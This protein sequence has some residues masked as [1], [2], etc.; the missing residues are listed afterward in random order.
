MKTKAKKAK[1]N[2]VLSTILWTLLSIVVL[3]LALLWPN[4]RT[5]GQRLEPADLG[6]WEGVYSSQWMSKLPEDTRLS[7]ISMAGSHD[8]GTEY[9]LLPLI[10]RCQD[11]QISQ[12][13][14]MGV[15]VLDIRLNSKTGKNGQYRLGISH[16]FVPCKAGSW[17]LG[18]DLS[19]ERVL[20]ECYTFLDENPTETILMMVKHEN[21]S[22]TADEIQEAVDRA[23]GDD[24]KYWFTENRDP[25][26]GEVR[27]KIVLARRYGEGEADLPG[28]DFCWENQG[29][30]DV[31]A[32]PCAQHKVNDDLSLWVQDRY[33]YNMED[34][35]DAITHCLS[36]EHSG[37]MIN[38][39]SSKGGGFQGVPQHYAKTLNKRY[40]E[41]QQSSGGIVMFDFVTP[42]LAEK[43]YALN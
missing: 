9:A 13:L 15:R 19:F 25:E 28:L 33:E 7:Q 6:E 3:I 21:G 38:Y 8:S 11:T 24:S 18:R 20:E 17:I 40:V 5:F 10:A 4:G 34:K 42:E 36:C 27:G 31:C 22:G 16:G 12:Q 39:L 30:T 37:F 29:G 32:E 23:I 26:L 41:T 35:W 1:G 43:V 2:K 14:S